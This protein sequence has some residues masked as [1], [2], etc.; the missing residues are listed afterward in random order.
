MKNCPPQAAGLLAASIFGF[1]FV[2]SKMALE[3]AQPIQLI[4]F[5]FLVAFMLLSI[6]NALGWIKISLRGKNLKSL[7]LVA[8]F[9]P[10]LYFIFETYALLYAPVSEMGLMLSLIPAFVVLLSAVFL[11]ERPTVLQYVFIILSIAGAALINLIKYNGFS[12]GRGTLLLL[13]ADLSA[14]CYFVFSRKAA[15]NF[16]S[17]E[18]TYVMMG[19]GAVIFNGLAALQLVSAG[20]LGQFFEPLWHQEFM[21]GLAYLGI[22]S[23]VGAFFLMN[24]NLSK[25]K[26][27]EVSVLL[28]LETVISI[29]TGVWFFG[30]HFYWYHFVG[31][32]LILFGAFGTNY[33]TP[34]VMNEAKSEHKA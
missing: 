24:Y 6:L 14:A 21:I 2:F 22:L 20:S 23:S 32:L 7:F 19:F 11:K 17:M 27:F 31:T 26:T 12:L 10:V 9:Q 30:D 33:F 34:S 4:G 16:S 5:R 18:I 8:L 15:S 25:L 13:L 1:S 29:A 3:Y 28:N